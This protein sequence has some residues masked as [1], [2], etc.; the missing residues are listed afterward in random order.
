M[1]DHLVRA[2]AADASVRAFAVTARELTEFARASH[3]TSPVITAALGRLMSGALMMGAMLKGE[4]DTVTLQ[5]SGDGPVK[6]LTARADGAGHVNGYALE[7]GV[8]LPANARGKLDVSGAIGKG[9]LRV[10]RDLHLKDP[11]VGTVDLISGEIA[12]DLTW[13]FA[14]SEQIPSSVGL[15]VLMNRDNT[16]RAAGGFILQMMPFVK[17]E[18]VDAIE[19]KLT[20]FPSVTSVLDQGAS[21]EDMLRMLLGDLGLEIT[22][23]NEV[24]FLCGCD[25]KRVEKSLISLGK[26][27]LASLAKDAAAIGEDG[28]EAGIE[29]RCQ[30]CNKAYHFNE[31]ELRALL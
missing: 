14:S 24:S 26:K 9:V 3:N 7:P 11:Y 31:K 2:V 28:K 29:L 30:V 17:D 25:R 23:K 6:G 21:P 16:V 15:G 4:A 8:I 20:A 12:E 22:A 1:K 27:E 19:E 5:I 13:Y 18:V 10:I